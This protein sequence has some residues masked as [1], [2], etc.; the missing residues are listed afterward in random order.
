MSGF[1][2]H[3]STC[4]I[5]NPILTLTVAFKDPHRPLAQKWLGLDNIYVPQPVFPSLH[6]PYF[7]DKDN[8]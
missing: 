2:T 1:F 6:F 8:P 3:L 5:L 4:N 7:L